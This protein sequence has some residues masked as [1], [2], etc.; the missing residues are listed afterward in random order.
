MSLLVGAFV[1]KSQGN[2]A[3]NEKLTTVRS[4]C[5]VDRDNAAK[6]M[7]YSGWAGQL[8]TYLAAERRVV[9]VSTGGALFVLLLVPMLLPLITLHSI[10]TSLASYA[11]GL[12]VDTDVLAGLAVAGGYL[13]TAEDELNEEQTSLAAERDAFIEFA[14]AV[15]SMSTANQPTY[16]TTTARVSKTRQGRQQ[17]EQVKET[18][19]NT[20]LALPD[21]QREYDETLFEH[22]SAEFGSDVASVIISGHQFSDPVK[23]LLVEQARQSA[24]QRQNLI[25][26]VRSEQRSLRRSRSKLDSTRSC[27]RSHSKAD[28]RAYSFDTLVETESTLRDA[29]EQCESVLETRQQDI[30]AA[31]NR[32]SCQEGF[33]QEYLY[34]DAPFTFPAL[35]TGITHI[36]Q[37]DERRT[38]LART[39][40]QRG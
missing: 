2:T 11:V 26:S 16:G 38:L 33:L 22:I 31:N 4:F 13:S 1:N 17:L 15:A 36:E 14:D 18:Y 21:F 37:L 23:Q 28:L 3:D 24:K 27:L 20:I 30:H 29:Q 19:H 12:K 7:S 40:S 25:D 5:P 34:K 39:L 6:R 32:F 10:A 8:I 9:A 35:C